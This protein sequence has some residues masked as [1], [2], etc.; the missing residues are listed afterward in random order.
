MSAGSPKQKRQPPPPAPQTLP[1][2]DPA[3][4]APA[5]MA[6]ISGVVTPGASCLRFSHS[7]AIWRPTSGQ[8]RALER[9]AHRGGD[10]ADARER[11]AARRASP[12]MCRLVTSQLLMPGVARRVGVGERRCAAA[13][14]PASTV[15]RDAAHA[16]DAELHGR[17]AAVVAPAGS[18]ARRSARRSPA[19]RRSSRSGSSLVGG[20][21]AAAPGVQ[22]AA[23][24]DVQR[25]RSGDAGADRRIGPRASARGPRPGSSA[26]AAPS[27][28]RSWLSRSCDQ[29]STSTRSLRVLRDDDQPPIA[30]RAQRRSCARRL[31]AALSVCAPS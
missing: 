8:S 11:C 16:V 29:C 28:G 15:E 25:R 3:R 17:D 21:M 26:A 6:S 27:S 30:A 9:R 20:A 5:S 24:R 18:P 14:P 4:A 12:S 10:V 23:D 19:P 22:R 2:S 1:P 13:A 31:I 7:A